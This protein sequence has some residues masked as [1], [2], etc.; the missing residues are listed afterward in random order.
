VI[1][2]TVKEILVGDI[3]NCI[4][5]YSSLDALLPVSAESGE[6]LAYEFRSAFAPCFMNSWWEWF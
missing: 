1:E 2:S 5:R 3:W 4:K 6:R